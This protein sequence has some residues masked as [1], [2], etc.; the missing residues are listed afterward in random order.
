MLSGI[1]QYL[2]LKH[3]FLRWVHGSCYDEFAMAQAFKV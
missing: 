1:N 3:K 2:P